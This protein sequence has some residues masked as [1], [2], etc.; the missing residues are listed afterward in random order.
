MP[1]S[2]TRKNSLTAGGGKG[3]R[4]VEPSH[5]DLLSASYSKKLQAEIKRGFKLVETRL[6]PLLPKLDSLQRVDIA[7]DAD[8][9]NE[10][11]NGILKSFFG[12]M[13]SK[14]QPNLKAYGREVSK[15]LVVPMQDNVDHFNATQFKKQFKRISG[16][17][18]LRF[19][20]GLFD[21]LEVAGNQNVN[22]IVT[23]SS[24]YFDQIREMTNRALRKGTSVKELKDQIVELTETTETKA[25]LIAIDQVQKLNADLEQTR[26]K[27]NGIQRYIWRTR[28]NARTR[29]DH[30]DLE[31]AIFSW[32]FP[33][34]T[35]TTGKR[36]GETN[37]PGQDINCFPAGT[38]IDT[39]SGQKAIEDIRKGDIVYSHGGEKK[40]VG[41]HNGRHN[42][43]LIGIKLLHKT[44][45]LTPNH[46]VFVGG[47]IGGFWKEA[48]TLKLTDKII[49][50][51]E[52]FPSGVFNENA[53]RNIK[54]PHPHLLRQELM[55][56]WINL[57]H[58]GL[59]LN[60]CIQFFKEKIS[61]IMDAIGFFG[62][63]KFPL[64]NII[65]TK[66]IKPS[67]AHDFSFG[68]HPVFSVPDARTK[69]GRTMIFSPFGVADPLQ[70]DRFAFG[71]DGQ[72]VMNQA[73]TSKSAS[74]A[75]YSSDLAKSIFLL[76]I[77]LLQ[78]FLKILPMFAFRST[79]NNSLLG[80]F[81]M[82]EKKSFVGAWLRTILG[83]AGFNNIRPCEKLFSAD[84]TETLYRHDKFSKQ[85]NDFNESAQHHYRIVDLISQ[86]YNGRV[87]NFEVKDSMS[88][89][90]EGILV[91]NCKCW[92]EIVI[93]DLTG[94]IS[95]ET[96]KAEEKT[97][98][99]I[100]AGRVPGYKLP[101]R[102][103]EA[104]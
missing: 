67:G 5:P 11:L 69:M 93:D 19:A 1:I 56:G 96:L 12:G 38:L 36:T 99:L 64:R 25:N 22:K 66:N 63:F 86:A 92:S 29:E 20:P 80:F 16:V 43:K 82:V 17:D 27:A 15:K 88:Y 9:I 51:K 57:C 45:W 65:N 59:N 70:G 10:V 37:H 60:N 34:V 30:K 61:L 6:F 104:A 74:H 91:A 73:F 58:S 54:H 48:R 50:L 83:F 102:K 8:R 77:M 46:K 14:E 21:A 3:R 47:R 52:I 101:K 7:N 42:G 81:N 55:A 13:L 41:L 35:V 49:E 68:N 78:P 85:V 28:R 53:A 75:K 44:I 103:K 90:A 39:P 33:P 26:Q 62:L 100:E 84:F 87:Y 24:V 40:V 32:E 97:Q 79:L 71:A 76:D 98:E 2:K 23:Q 31:G 89:F 18:P 94:D 4:P 72:A 95:P